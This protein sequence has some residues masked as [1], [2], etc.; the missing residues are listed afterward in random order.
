ML[1]FINASIFVA[2]IAVSIPLL[3]HLFNKQRRK[4]IPF[5]SIRFLQLL[6]KHRL[7]RLKL[8]EYLLIL[9]RSLVLLS[10][11]LAFARP[12]LSGKPVFSTQGARTTAVI[13]IDTGINM[14]RYDD[15]GNRFTRAKDLL[16]RLLKQF[17]PEDQVFIIQTTDPEEVFQKP[18]DLQRQNASYANSGWNSSLIKAEKLLKDHPNFNRELYIISDFQYQE[19]AFDFFCERNTDIYVFLLKIGSSVVANIGIDTLEIKNQIFEINKPI[20]IDIHLKSSALEQIQPIELH[21]FVNNQRVSHR[22]ISIGSTSNI[23]IPLSFQPKKSGFISGYVKISDDDLLADNKYFF[24]LKIPSE[25]KILNV[26]DNPSAFI[27]AALLSL[28]K[29]T[30]IR[31]TNE[32]FNSW[33][34][35]NFQQYNILLLNNFPNFSAQI[36]QRLK[37]FLDNGGSMILIP[38]MNTLPAEFNR[39]SVM[40][41]LSSKIKQLVQIGS[42][43][44]FFILQQPDLNHPLFNGLFRLDNPDLLKPKFYRYFKFSLS[45]KD[46]QILSFQNGDPFIL[47]LKRENGTIFIFSSYIDDEW[48][49]IQYRGLFIPFLSRL[50]YLSVSNTSQIQS[51]IVVENEKI[52]SVRQITNAGD[53]YMQIP[54]G[55]KSTIIP[56][57]YDQNYLFHLTHL[58]QPGLYKIWSGNDILSTIPVNV[59]TDVLFE[60]SLDLEALDNKFEKIQ[61]YSE[62]DAFEKEINETRFGSELWKF[63]IVLSL[64]LLAV[65]LFF[66]KKMEGKHSRRD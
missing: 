1:T 29:N 19:D 65:E 52:L 58:A 5:S 39:L 17:K 15:R 34:R 40:L 30:N 42:R 53:F 66:I 59:N 10:L 20:N 50:F 51:S 13:L 33:A 63:F 47:E 31:I 11:I 35:Q 23:V 41:G 56:H 46:L 25:I 12:T 62:R 7:R 8:Y 32:R 27:E 60:L 44:K 28:D 48:T 49:D 26:D 61:I 45:S 55:E 2:V 38:G 16:N 3:I 6:E 21:L 4:K 54:D 36:V 43:D 22:T 64:L 57:R 14:R 18:I 9:L 37:K 24:A